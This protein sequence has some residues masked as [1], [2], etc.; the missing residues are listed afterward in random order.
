VLEA[1]KGNLYAMTFRGT[2]GAWSPGCASG[3][4]SSS[5][6]AHSERTGL[7]VRDTAPL[8][9][10]GPPTSEAIAHGQSSWG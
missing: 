9:T 2:C 7:I 1:R 5:V 6:G 8:S 4:V 3:G 10:A